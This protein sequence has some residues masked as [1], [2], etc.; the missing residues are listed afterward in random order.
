VGLQFKG[1]FLGEYDG[2]E[3]WRDLGL[4]LRETYRAAS[5][6]PH[7]VLEDLFPRELISLAEKQELSRA[8]RLEVHHSRRVKKAESPRVAA[9]SAAA[10][11]FCLMEGPS[12]VEFLTGLTGIDGLEPDPSH[13][14][15]GLHANGRG[16]FQAV[17]TDFPR[18][19]VTGKWHRVN[20]L[21]YLNSSWREEYGGALELWPRTMSEVG[22]EISPTAG[23]LIVF[24][25]NSQT[26][27]G[28]PDPLTCP[29]GVF[30]LS[31]AS[32]YYTGQ[33]SS[34]V[35]LEPLLRRPR[36]PQDPWRVGIAEP[37]E[38]VV[39]LAERLVSHTPQ[40]YGLL[41]RVLARQMAR[42]DQNSDRGQ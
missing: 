27:H 11:L 16:S 4:R 30:R 40:A 42:L 1:G 2:A 18:Q 23:R 28:I 35:R 32:Y 15:S 25:T 9:G 20:A 7:V 41:D 19:R 26:V 6:W 39:G 29:S 31:L 8:P 17:H 33:P 3:D 10:E 13:L 21:L 12:F 38:I 36:R 14:L 34:D 24:E 37:A 22:T 5:P